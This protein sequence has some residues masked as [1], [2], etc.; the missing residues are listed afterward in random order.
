[1]LYNNCHI[2][3]DCSS[4]VNG[5]LPDPN[6]CAKFIH[7]SNG[8]AYQKQCGTGL[9]WNTNITGCDYPANVGCKIT[10]GIYKFNFS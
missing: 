5:F 9:H 3:S 7:C 10:S 6:D 1:M 8:V 2:I 4:I